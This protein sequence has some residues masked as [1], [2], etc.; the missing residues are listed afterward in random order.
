MG[1]DKN[2]GMVLYINGEPWHIDPAAGL[3]E[4]TAKPTEDLPAIFSSSL[5]GSASCVAVAF[6]AF[7]ELFTRACEALAQIM[8]E[9]AEFIAEIVRA[10]VTFERAMEAAE[11]ER[12]KWVAIYRRTKKART[13]KKYEKRIL[14]WYLEEVETDA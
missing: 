1:E 3:P 8:D 6:S 2:A 9:V 4:I 7:A 14:R 11:R 10:Q 13:R 12:P 5:A